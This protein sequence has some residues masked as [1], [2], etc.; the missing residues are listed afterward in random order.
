MIRKQGSDRLVVE[1]LDKTRPKLTLSRDRDGTL[2]IDLA[3]EYVTDLP[4]IEIGLCLSA[5]EESAIADFVGR[6]PVAPSSSAAPV[7][8]T[9][10][11]CKG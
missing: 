10:G 6:R 5:A 11:R 2:H 4:G 7:D 1:D 8:A 3:Q 9:E